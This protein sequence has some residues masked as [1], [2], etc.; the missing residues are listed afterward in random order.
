MDYYSI[1]AE[2]AMLVDW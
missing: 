1:Q 2:L